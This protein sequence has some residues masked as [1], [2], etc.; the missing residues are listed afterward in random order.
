M[1]DLRKTRSP[2]ISDF[3]QFIANDPV[4]SAN[5]SPFRQDYNDM[6]T[7]AA[8]SQ[9][10]GPVQATFLMSGNGAGAAL[11]NYHTSAV[12]PQSAEY[13]DPFDDNIASC[14][15]DV[16][17]NF[18]ESTDNMEQTA[19]HVP[20]NI[21]YNNLPAV[22][23]GNAAVSSCGIFPS[24]DTATASRTS[25]WGTINNYADNTSPTRCGSSIGDMINNFAGNANATASGSG[26]GGS[27]SNP[28]GSWGGILLGNSSVTASGTTASN[29]MHGNISNESTATST[30][31]IVGTIDNCPDN[32]PGTNFT[33]EASPS[34]PSTRLTY[35][36]YKYNT[37]LANPT[38]D[39]IRST[40]LNPPAAQPQARLTAPRSA[41][42]TQFNFNFASGYDQLASR[43]N[44]PLLATDVEAKDMMVERADP[45]DRKPKAG[46]ICCTGDHQWNYHVL[47][48]K[49]IALKK[50][51]AKH[52]RRTA[53]VARRNQVLNKEL[54]EAQGQII[55]LQGDRAMLHAMRAQKWSERLAQLLQD[56]RPGAREAAIIVSNS[57]QKDAKITQMERR[58]A[59]NQHEIAK[60]KAMQERPTLEQVLE[61]IPYM[62]WIDYSVFLRDFLLHHGDRH[63]I[64]EHL[65]TIHHGD[66][67]EYNFDGLSEGNPVPDDTEGLDDEMEDED[68]D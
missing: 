13:R 57:A 46:A 49:Y 15:V 14:G 26:M 24:S 56:T 28:N 29:R 52:Q 45:T 48:D 40:H 42:A 17:R 65:N 9:S 3:D 32:A 36:A 58:L 68:E 4:N 16:I 37:L 67:V 41:S 6:G 19:G 11:G 7:H 2:G 53:R 47:E 30:N 51:Y 20:G 55:V 1:S 25:M 66:G 5:S 59:L 63:N 22:L 44:S 62:D 33:Y 10:L 60:L 38:V 43:A 50:V 64:R 39:A 12:T 35:R 23:A 34:N 31:F 21:P 18:T 61:L 27:I 54:Q 8:L